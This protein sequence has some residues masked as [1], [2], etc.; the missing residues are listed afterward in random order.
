MFI[1]FKEKEEDQINTKVFSPSNRRQDYLLKVIPHIYSSRYACTNMSEQLG[2]VTHDKA[3]R[4]PMAKPPNRRITTS[5]TRNQ[6][7]TFL[8]DLCTQ[9]FS[10]T[11]C[12]E[13]KIFNVCARNN[14]RGQHSLK[15]KSLIK[16]PKKGLRQATDEGLLYPVYIFP[17]HTSS[18]SL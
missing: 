18:K 17:E 4:L 14:S 10:W 2:I 8:K 5:E 3:Y 13:D 6:E 1:D 11:A 7:R 12:F 16:V 9:Q 15:T